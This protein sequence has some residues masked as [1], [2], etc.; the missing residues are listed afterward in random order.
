MELNE[1]KK[2]KHEIDIQIIGSD[3]SLKAVETASNNMNYAE[4]N[5]FVEEG[6]LHAYDH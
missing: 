3:V 6:S 2:I 4:L 1:F 5:S